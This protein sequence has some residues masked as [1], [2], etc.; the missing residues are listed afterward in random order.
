MEEWQE[1][2]HS[3]SLIFPSPPC[4]TRLMVFEQ[5]GR[6]SESYIGGDQSGRECGDFQ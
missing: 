4:S 2:N 5:G 1:R 6:N 3:E